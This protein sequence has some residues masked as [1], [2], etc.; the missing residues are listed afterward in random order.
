MTDYDSDSVL[1]DSVQTVLKLLKAA[2]GEGGFFKSFY[3]GDPDVIPAMNLP[4]LVVTKTGDDGEPG[5]N[6]QDD[7]TETLVVKAIL[8]K[9]DDWDNKVDPIN[10]S[11]RKLRGV[12]EA[13]DRTTRKWLPN[14]IRG[15]LRN[16][17]DSDVP[18]PTISQRH[19]LQIGVTPRPG[20]LVTHEAHLTITVQYAVDVD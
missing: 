1:D 9:K 4:A 17:I 14:T 2:I 16:E 3:D 7:I 12:M 19:S 8:D 18:H 15:A 11:E 6:V 10:M 13:R 5:T 20:N